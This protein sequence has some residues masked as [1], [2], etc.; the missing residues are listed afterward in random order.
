MR[1]GGRGTVPG[2]IDLTGQ[3]QILDF[4][5]QTACKPQK[6]AASTLPYT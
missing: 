2:L 1:E 3:T 5:M 4:R 6:L